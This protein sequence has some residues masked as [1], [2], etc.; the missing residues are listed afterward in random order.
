[1]LSVRRRLHLGAGAAGGCPDRRGGGGGRKPPGGSGGGGFPGP[2][3]PAGWG[4][5]T[6]SGSLVFGIGTRSN[7]GLGG[8][9]VIP[10][11]DK[12]TL[13]TAFPA[14]GTRYPE[15]FIDSGSNGIY[16]L[17]GAA[18][19]IPT[20]TGTGGIERF[21]CPPSPMVL[22]AANQGAGGTPTSPVSFS[23]ANANALF[24]SNNVAFSN[25][26]GENAGIPSLHLAAA[27][28]W[29]LAFFFG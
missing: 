3:R 15:S 28:D 22:S 13:T 8:A 14:Q 20:C 4:A 12:G 6:A 21:Y 24:A 27:F 29:G 18:T 23:I 16:F 7:N 25:L 1:M 2:P 9:V 10:V 11:D 17:S 26:G 19:G 5:P